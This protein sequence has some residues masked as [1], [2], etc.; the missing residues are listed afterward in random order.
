MKNFIYLCFFLLFL[1]SCK[2][3]SDLSQKISNDISDSKNKFSENK[4]SF[5][6]I[7]DKKFIDSLKTV[8][9]SSIIIPEE[10][11]H[12]LEYIKD[13]KAKDTLNLS[14][15]F[16]QTLNRGKIITYDFN[17][18]KNDIINYEF[19]NNK[20]PKIEEILIFEG[21]QIRFSHINL[22]RNEDVLGSFKI[23]SENKIILQIKNNGLFKSNLKIILDNIS[24]NNNMQ[25]VKDSI[26][27]KEN[28]IENKI[29]TLFV[30]ENSKTF[31]LPPYLDITNDTELTIP[32]SFNKEEEV[33]AWGF[34]ISMMNSDLENYKFYTEEF[35]EEPLISYAKSEFLKKDINYKLPISK[36]PYVELK[37]ESN[38]QLLPSIN[39]ERNF[40]FFTNKDSVFSNQQ[41]GFLYLKNFSKLYDFKL[42]LKIVKVIK[43]NRLIEKE[44]NIVKDF[45]K[46]KNDL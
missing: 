29:D 21:D 36:N 12:L 6:N 28:L 38:N 17:V 27:G 30:L 19:R 44:K 43:S 40:N 15:L 2:S 18:K 13:F 46:I 39:S 33:I 11:F 10:K 3:I 20:S 24:E 7:S 8:E 37:T 45:I 22:K 23:L 26:V 25:T 1:Y 41:K 32:I 4:N 16:I 35:G 34:W 31:I 9:L 14:N 42:T 5:L